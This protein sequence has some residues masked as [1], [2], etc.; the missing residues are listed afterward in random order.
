[1]P[2]MVRY[3][4][5]LRKIL[6]AFEWKSIDD[7]ETRSVV[8]NNLS[9]GEIVSDLAVSPSNTEI[10]YVA[11]K[12][13]TQTGTI[14]SMCESSDGGANLNLLGTND[15]THPVLSGMEDIV[16]IPGECLS[17][18]KKNLNYMLSTR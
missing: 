18:M 14:S 7:G 15:K 4:V 8:R 12:L 16:V 10:V 17:K 9:R 11:S 2:M 1:M 3:T 13:S 6:W 5:L